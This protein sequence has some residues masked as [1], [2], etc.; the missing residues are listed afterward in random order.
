M[1][2][3]SCVDRATKSPIALEYLD[4]LG[5]DVPDAVKLVVVT[6]WHDDHIKGISSVFRTAE[7]ATIVCS[8]AL[9]NR[10][11]FQV[12]AASERAMTESPGMGEFS[13]IFA[14]LEERAPVGVRPASIGP[15]WVMENQCLF[16]RNAAQTCPAEVHAL[17]PSSGSITLALRGIGQLLPQYNAPK[18]R[19]VALSPN[20]IAVVLWFK[21]GDIRVLLGA[22]LEETPSPTTGWKA[23]VASTS[24]PNDR[25]PIFKVPHHGSVNADSPDVWSH[26]LEPEP[27]AVL[28][29]FASGTSPLPSARDFARLSKRTPNLYCTASPDG[30]S[31][32][33]RD[34]A[35]EKTIRDVAPKRRAI[36]GPMGHVRMRSKCS[37][38]PIS[39]DLFNG[40][41]RVTSRIT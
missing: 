22:D 33:K 34:P 17:S 26:M 32:P 5:V 4:R 8:A 35:V 9:R 20:Q 40:A 16:L 18:R 36:V 28:T 7:S 12:V 21:V 31:P 1:V 11:F 15:Q 41:Y 14:I 23:I 39:V 30:W 3:D 10:E 29:P 37:S 38:P 13:A 24:R 25:A 27:V 19:A 2:V 6:H